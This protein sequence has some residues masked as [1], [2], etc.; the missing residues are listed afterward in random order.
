MRSVAIIV[1]LCV[2]AAAAPCAQPTE[3]PSGCHYFP[4]EA[5]GYRADGK[6]ESY[7]METVYDYMDGGAEVY[8]AYGMK[9]LRVARYARKEEPPIT[10]DLF[11]MEDAAGAFG[12]FT[13]ERLDE[14]AGIG[15]GSEYGGGQLRFWQGRYFAFIQTERETQA[16][17]LAVLELGKHLAER[18]GPDEPA[19]KLAS[20]LPEEGL[21]PLSVRFVRSPLLL[22]TMER[23][24]LG[25]PLG[26]PRRC[27]AVVGRYGPRGGPERVLVAALPSEEGAALSVSAYLGAKFPGAEAVKPFEGEGGWCAVGSTGS[28]AVV[29]LGAPSPS[30]AEARLE[31][32]TR[33]AKGVTP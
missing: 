22:E 23:T 4:R 28:C 16:S 1:V 15:Q 5:A 18:L 31:A 11:E 24:A 12:A 19:P 33:K 2:A 17:R 26:L 6:A 7:D 13:F 10:V 8:L 9:L 29:V 25:N 20:S 32:V 3:N 30:D 14:E 27:E 21:R